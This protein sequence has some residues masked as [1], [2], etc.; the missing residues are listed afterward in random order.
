MKITLPS[1]LLE[2]ETLNVF[3]VTVVNPEGEQQKHRLRPAEFR[4]IVAASNF[5]Q[6]AR[7]ALLYYHAELHNYGC[8]NT[9]ENEHGLGFFVKFGDG[10]MDVKPIAHPTRRSTNSPNSWKSRRRSETTADIRH[11]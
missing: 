7:A 9:A 10:A 3:S 1:G 5:K 6:R 2:H 11:A 8:R 4:Q